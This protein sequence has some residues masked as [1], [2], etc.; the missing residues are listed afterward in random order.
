MWRSWGHHQGGTVRH[1]A[2]TRCSEDASCS[3]APDNM[4]QGSYQSGPR[5]AWQWE[6]RAPAHPQPRG[7][8]PGPCLPTS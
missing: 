7:L 6:G 3:M 8:V 4:A 1:P 2:Q 5:A